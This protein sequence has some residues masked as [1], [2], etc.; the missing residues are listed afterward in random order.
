[1]KVIGFLCSLI[2]RK[3]YLKSLKTKLTVFCS[4]C[5]PTLQPKQWSEEKIMYCSPPLATL[6]S[7][8]SPVPLKSLNNTLTQPQPM[9]PPTTLP[10]W[11]FVQLAMFKICQHN[12]WRGIREKERGIRETGRMPLKKN[13][14]S[15]CHGANI[16]A[17]T[18]LYHLKCHFYDG[19]LQELPHNCCM[20]VLHV[21]R[22]N[23]KVF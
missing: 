14:P 12:I 5:F 7:Q 11:I 10:K 16:A 21:V 20:F 13:T 18:I 9:L 22:N 4:T 3:D 17:S 8:F 2:Q 1:M 6:I 15:K 23:M 19:M